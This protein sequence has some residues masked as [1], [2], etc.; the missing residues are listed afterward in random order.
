[1]VDGGLARRRR[2]AGVGL[3]MAREIVRLHKGEIEVRSRPGEGTVFSVRLPR[4]ISV[5][6]APE[7]HV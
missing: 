6:R 3:Y 7:A 2:G 4:G 1:M 5:P